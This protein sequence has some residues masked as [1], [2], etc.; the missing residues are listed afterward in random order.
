MGDI[1]FETAK[2]LLIWINEQSWCINKNGLWNNMFNSGG[3]SGIE[4]EQMINFF[5][6]SYAE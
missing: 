5:L 4:I 2:Q 3:E 6:D 1:T